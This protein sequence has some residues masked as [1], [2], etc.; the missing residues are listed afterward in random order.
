MLDSIRKR[1]DNL[2]YTA[3]ILAVVAVMALFGVN[4]MAGDN[5]R[6]KDGPAAWVNGELITRKEFQ[7]ELQMKLMQYQA[8][9]G[10]NYDEKFLTALQVPQRTLEELVQY[11]LLAQ[12]AKRLGILVPDEELADYIRTL[13]YYQ[14][15][16]KFDAVLYRKLPNRGSEEKR[17]REKLQTAK[18]QTYLSDRIRLTPSELKAVIAVQE[19]KVNLELAKLDFNALAMKAKPTAADVAA[20][21]KATPEKT[22]TDYF[23][24]HKKEFV[25]KPA[26]RLHQIRVGIPYQASESQKGEA[27]Q[28]IEGIAKNLTAANFAEVAKKESDDEYAKKGGEV[29]WVDRGTLEAGLETVIDKLEPNQVSAPVETSFGFYVVKVS[30]KRA[31]K[32]R[33][34]EEVKPRIVEQLLLEKKKKEFAETKRKEI[35][36]LLASGKKVEPALKALGAEVKKTGPFSLGG[37]FVPQVGQAEPVLDAVFQLTPKDPQVKA[38]IPY[39]DNY[40]Y[41]KLVSF[42]APKAADFQKTSETVARSVEGQMQSELVTKWV[43]ELQKRASVKTEL[44]F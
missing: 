2:I 40:Y 42:E 38:L 23:E 26:V 3:L 11:K 16:G 6:S 12:Q 36:G 30:D 20:F 4:Q 17:Y 37:G 34:F 8:M 27:R 14:R 13:P 5:D 22:L 25:D 41:V 35:D 43:G 24:E 7:Q 15:D 33:S 31:E 9:L 28:K 29:G 39:Q 1:K 10:G 19:T 18:L 32:T 44:K 21:T